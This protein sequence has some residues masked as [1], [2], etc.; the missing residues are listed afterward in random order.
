MDV[1]DLRDNSQYPTGQFKDEYKRVRY[2]QKVS[3][4]KETWDSLHQ[5]DCTTLQF[6]VERGEP[7]VEV[8]LKALEDKLTHNH[9][10]SKI[11]SVSLSSFA[12]SNPP[13]NTYEAR[14]REYF[15]LRLVG[16]AKNLKSLMYLGRN[17]FQ[18]WK[19]IEENSR[20]AFLKLL[21]ENPEI[22][23]E[24]TEPF[25]FKVRILQ[26]ISQSYLHIIKKTCMGLDTELSMEFGFV[27]NGKGTE[28]VNKIYFF[29]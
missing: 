21:R 4:P 25:V 29:Y 18:H 1:V 27:L 10:F 22:E 14:H 28:K 20:S 19:N 6:D 17:E 15:F 11:T 23:F 9:L 8:S 5:P 7:V 24:G 16:E 13:P 12:L 3:I 26:N 2:I